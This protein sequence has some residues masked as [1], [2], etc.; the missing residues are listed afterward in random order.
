VTGMVIDTAAVAAVLFEETGA[1]WLVGAIAEAER[2]YMCAGTYVELGIVIES[3]L[4]P[5]GAV[6][7]FVRDAEVELVDVTFQV[8]NRALDGW[9]RFGK[10]RNSAGLNFGDC[11]TYGLAAEWN[12]PILCVGEN[13][14][15]TDIDTLTPPRGTTANR[16][17]ER[18]E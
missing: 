2:R 4:G 8:A 10:G 11:F 5:T 12:L 13:F 15:K 16:V 1:E 6:D 3:R 17:V 18:P 14:A 7:R 9:R